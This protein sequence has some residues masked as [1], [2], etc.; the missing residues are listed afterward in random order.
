MTNRC[1]ECG[2]TQ[3]TTRFDVG[4]KSGVSP[5]NLCPECW[6]QITER[7]GRCGEPAPDA[8]EWVGPYGS[9]TVILP[10]CPSCRRA[11][12]FEEVTA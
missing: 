8:D 11:L 12:L 4:N 9:G 2:A 1:A 3:D 10:L 6:E 7:C 5:V